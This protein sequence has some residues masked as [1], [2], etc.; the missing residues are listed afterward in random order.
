MEC[1]VD[2]TQKTPADVSFRI[3]RRYDAPRELV[4]KAWTEAER[5]ARWW[6]P[7]DF[8]LKVCTLEFSPG[9]V[10]H[11][12]MTTPDGV[13][14]W[15]LF[16]YREI[17]EPERLVWLNS[18]AD[19]TGRPVRNPWDENWPLSMLIDMKLSESEGGTLLELSSA[20]FEA[21]AEEE[22]TFYAGHAS[23]TQGF[24]GTLDKLAD[25]IARLQ[26]G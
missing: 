1:T 11:Y 6:G 26:E 3:S 21:T 24:G 23:M 15:G 16:R 7:K 22:A 14:M 13:E 19:A 8:G 2:D 20:P 12:S 18:F 4:F 17:A 25:E 10:F 9:G 5:L